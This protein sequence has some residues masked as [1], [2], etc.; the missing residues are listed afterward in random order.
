MLTSFRHRR[1]NFRVAGRDCPLTAPRQAVPRDRP[2]DDR[3]LGG[4]AHRA[5]Q[6]ASSGRR[7]ARLSVPGLVG[8]LHHDL[9]SHS[10]A[11]EID[12]SLHG[13]AERDD[14]LTTVREPFLAGDPLTFVADITTATELEQVLIEGLARR[15]GRTTR[16]DSFRYRDSAPPVRRAA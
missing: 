13:D 6:H 5:D 10:L 14:F 15:G 9:G 4:S 3:R 7:L 12:G 2:A 11:V 16:R 8:D 1:V